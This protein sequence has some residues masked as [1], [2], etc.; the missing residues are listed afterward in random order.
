MKGYTI[1]C[2]FTMEHVDGWFHCEVCGNKRKAT[3]AELK[4]LHE[5]ELKPVIC[6]ALRDVKT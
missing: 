5:S 4:A 1:N 3:P 2:P 6:R